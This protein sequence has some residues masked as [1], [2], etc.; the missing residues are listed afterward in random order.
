[1]KAAWLNNCVF[2]GTA[3]DSVRRA[4]IATVNQ[5]S[6]ICIGGKISHLC[7]ESQ[8]TR[9]PGRVLALYPPSIYEDVC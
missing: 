9:G 4:L 7:S 3:R 6:Y 2:E 1:M 8:H 5:L